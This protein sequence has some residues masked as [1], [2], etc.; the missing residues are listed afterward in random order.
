[1][2]DYLALMHQSAVEQV[3]DLELNVIGHVIEYDVKTNMARLLLPTRR[4]EDEEDGGEGEQTMETGWCQVGSPIVGDGWGLQYC[5]KGGATKENPEE[6][7]QVQV[8]IQHRA[9][10]LSAV[11]NLTF[12]D[13]MKPPGAGSDNETPDEPGSD[14]AESDSDGAKR[15]KPAE[16]ILKHESGSFLKFYSNGSVRATV[17]ESLWVEVKQDC[18]L[19]VLEGDLNVSVEQGNANVTVDLGDVDIN[20]PLGNITI[21][22][23]EGTI[24]A[25]TES[26]DVEIESTAGSV[27]VNGGL[28]VD[29]SS[30]A[31]ITAT[32]PLINVLGA[33]VNI[34]ADIF[35]SLCTEAFLEWANLHIHSTGSGVTGP[36]TML[37]IPGIETTVNL[38][39]S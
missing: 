10:G 28:S 33:S 22:T 8:S 4:A 7:E 18:N 36:P 31:E 16:F 34:G 20:A 9:S 38:R 29:I 2:N 15:L 3:Q 11:A 5:L 23:L 27:K 14:P 1:M 35:Q 13:E 21:E 26:G 32:A 30:D 12:N 25:T 19:K 37:A 17:E 39:A 24:K 6:G